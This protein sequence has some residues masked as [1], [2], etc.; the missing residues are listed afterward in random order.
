MAFGS[1]QEPLLVGF[2]DITYNHLSVPEGLE[3]LIPQGVHTDTILNGTILSLYM[4]L[5]TTQISLVLIFQG[6]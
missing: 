3:L 4:S 5:Q 2:R 6:R 1:P